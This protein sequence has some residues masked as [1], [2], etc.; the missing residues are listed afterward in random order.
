MKKRRI[1]CLILLITLIFMIGFL[2]ADA[3]SV[4]LKLG[5]KEADNQHSSIALKKF[6]E[7]VEE[8]TNG[9]IKVDLFLNEVLGTPDTQLENTIQGV[10]DIYVVGH[11]VMSKYVKDYGATEM[12]YFFKNRDHF[13]KFLESDLVAEMEKELLEKTGLRVIS[14]V[15]N[16]W[17]GPYRYIAS[18]KPIF[19]LE[20]IKGLRLRAP[21]SKMVIK[22]WEGLGAN[23]TVIPWSE[24]YLA[25]SQGMVEAVT[26]AMVG[27]LSMKFYEVAPYITYSDEKFQQNCILMN[28]AKF[29][30][31]TKEQQQAIYDA[32]EEAGEYNTKL[33]Y[34]VLDKEL[35]EMKSK[36]AKFIEVDTTPWLIQANKTL[37][38]MEARGEITKG[39]MDKVDALYP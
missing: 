23:C 11:Y 16:W 17:M 26:G 13:Q 6:A 36:G 9:E 22:I 1:F 31:L 38:E 10:Q 2:S 15:R 24:V 32:A 28:N 25:L 34:E 3:A 14:I 39:L 18:K 21:D 37:S 7:L 33:L 12:K 5:N 19:T 27:C 8:K 29:E 4:T 20:D 35:K 30:S